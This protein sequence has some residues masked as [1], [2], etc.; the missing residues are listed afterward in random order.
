[1]PAS[2]LCGPAGT[3]LRPGRSCAPSGMPT[4]VS[5]SLSRCRPRTQPKTPPPPR[6]SR[7]EHLSVHSDG[8]RASAPSRSSR[9][10]RRKPRP[11]SSR[12][13]RCPSPTPELV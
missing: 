12:T 4:S 1:M 6:R 2:S 7:R 9:R 8:G 11:S 10:P 3:G 13:R 5:G